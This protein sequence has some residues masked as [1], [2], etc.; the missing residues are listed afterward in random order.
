[1]VAGRS[2]GKPPAFSR[3]DVRR[4]IDKLQSVASDALARDLARDEFEE[5]VAEK[6]SWH[7]KR[8]KGFLFDDRKWAFLDWFDERFRGRKRAFIYVFW[9]RRR[10]VYVGKTARSGRRIASHFDKRWFGPVTRLDVYAM[11]GRRVLPA[12]E[13]L[14][15]HRFQPTRNKV[16]A[17]SR[18]WTRKCELCS[19]HREIEEEVS[20]IFR[21]QTPRPRRK[22]RRR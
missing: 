1:M 20:S 2:P 9:N 6:R 18:K 16:K 17:E 10:C 7:A 15:I 14:S 21:L 19:I 5:G 8:G 11:R 3:K 13:C 4:A 22:R 12:L